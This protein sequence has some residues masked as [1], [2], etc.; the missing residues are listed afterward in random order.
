MK[1][2]KTSVK[3][4]YVKLISI[5]EP[6]DTQIDELGNNVITMYQFIG[7]ISDGKVPGLESILNYINES[8]YSKDEPAINEHRY[9]AIKNNT[10][11]K[12]ITYT[13]YIYIYITKTY[14]IINNRY[15]DDHYDNK[16]NRI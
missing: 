14:N 13:I 2:L 9:H 11:K 8:F 5:A 16:K 3:Y 1:P 10:T 7:I 12:H 6:I 4:L 15:T